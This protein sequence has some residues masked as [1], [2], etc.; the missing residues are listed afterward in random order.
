MA[1]ST[2]QTLPHGSFILWLH[3]VRAT[4]RTDNSSKEGAIGGLRF[5]VPHNTE[6]IVMF[7]LALFIV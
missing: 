1:G 5:Y 7:K 4:Q 3:L 6:Y 2:N